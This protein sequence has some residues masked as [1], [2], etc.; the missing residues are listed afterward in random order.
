MWWVY[1]RFNLLESIAREY[2]PYRKEIV[3]R[4]DNGKYYISDG[5]H[6]VAILYA[7]GYK[8]VENVRIK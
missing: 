5:H 3:V 1:D 8:K 6:R 7:L 2:N 4:E